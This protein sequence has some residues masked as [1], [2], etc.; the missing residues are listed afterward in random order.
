MDNHSDMS[1]YRIAAKARLTDQ[2][3][4]NA[5]RYPAQ[6]PAPQW[7]YISVRPERVWRRRPRAFVTNQMT[8]W[9]EGRAVD[10]NDFY[11]TDR[12][13]A[14]VLLLEGHELTQVALVAARVRFVFGRD[15]GLVDT[16]QRYYTDK[17]GADQ[18]HLR[19]ALKAIEDGLQVLADWTKEKGSERGF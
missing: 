4:I 15:H 1:S 17:A 10:P 14:A 5:L 2:A 16:L 13:L 8:D 9:A 11:V 3:L 19:L 12:K 6:H 18:K 7:K